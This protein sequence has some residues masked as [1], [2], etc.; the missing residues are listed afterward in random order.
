M[1]KCKKCEE[2]FETMNYKNEYCPKCYNE[3]CS[4]ALILMENKEAEVQHKIN[5]E[6]IQQIEEK[7]IVSDK[8]EDETNKELEHINTICD[9]Q[10]E[11]LKRTKYI[12]E[13]SVYPQFYESLCLNMEIIQEI[14]KKLI[15]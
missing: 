11:L 10:L 8:Y 5:M 9:I 12:I 3:M 13:D 4:E 15:I 7:P 1:K 14:V 6:E 2:W